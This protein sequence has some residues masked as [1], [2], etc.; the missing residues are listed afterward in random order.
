MSFIRGFLITVQFF[1]AIPINKEF[2]MDPEHL[3]KAV[4]A[5]PLLG[6]LQGIIYSLLLYCFV[7]FSPFTHLASAFILW[8]MTIFLTGG[9]HLDGWMDT[10]DA[11]FSYRDQEK[12]LSIMKDPRTGAFGVLSVIVLLSMR[13]FFIYEMTRNPMTSTYL[14]IAAIPFFSKMVMGCLL[15]SVKS[16]KQEGLGY[17]F[18]KAADVKSLFIYLFYLVGFILL[19]ILLIHEF[20]QTGIMLLAA[21]I[22]LYFWRRKSMKWFGGMTGDVLGAA[23]EGTEVGLWMTLWLLHYFVTA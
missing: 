2:P 23:V 17:L 5:F 10:S 9:I 11:Y 7:E 20:V 21:V 12:R 8:L 19:V 1:T 22:S 4:Q 13:L 18:Q 16:A 14:L 6:L 3:K 15:L